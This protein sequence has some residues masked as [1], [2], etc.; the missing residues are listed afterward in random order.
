MPNGGITRRNGPRT[1]SVIWLSM[2]LIVLTIGES[3]ANMVTH[4]MITRA[5][6]ASDKAVRNRFMKVAKKF[7][8][9]YLRR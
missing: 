2:S 6:I 9:P 1:G 8:C 5:S 4:D 3:G 7:N